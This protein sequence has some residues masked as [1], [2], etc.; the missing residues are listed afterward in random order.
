VNEQIFNNRYRVEGRVGEGGMAV[1]FSGTDVLL[2]RRV[3]IKVLR[4][5]YA[6]D[7]DF[8]RRFY[9]EA[10][11]A[12]R[13]SHPNVVN[14][15]DVGREGETYYIVMELVDGSTLGELIAIDGVL[16]SGIAIDY[17]AQICAGL[18]YAHRQGILH[19]DIKPANILITKDD[20]VKLS[21]FGIARAI[22]ERSLAVT[23]PGMVMGSVYYLSP[24]QAQG[25]ELFEQSDLYSVGVVLFQMLTGKLPFTG[26]SPVTV[27]LKHVS[28]PVPEHELEAAGVSPAVRSVV[29]RLLA[30]APADRFS[31]ASEVA[32]VLR[33]AR[34][35]PT[36]V[37]AG[38]AGGPTDTPTTTIPVVTPPPRRSAS[39]DRPHGTSNGES[40]DVALE[41]RPQRG[42]IGLWA[43][44]AVLLAVGAF[45]GYLFESG[46]P[47]P[48]LPGRTV[49]LG[50]Y[51]GES[52]TQAQQALAVLGITPKVTSIE[53]STIPPDRVVRQTPD[54]GSSVS[55]N[56]TI[57]LF[58]SSGLPMVGVPDVRT[59][60]R[61][62]AERVLAQ[63]KLR[64]KVVQQ[65][66]DAPQDTVLDLKPPAG[67]QVHED[68]L[69]TLVVSQG[70]SPIPVPNV[71][72]MSVDDA[73]AA[74]DKVGLKLQIGERQPSANIPENTIA[75]QDPK[76]GT[77]IPP[78]SAVT[79][80][81][82]GGP[83]PVTVPDVTGK[84]THDAVAMLQ[85]AGLDP[86]FSYMV[87]AGSPG[88]VLREV[89]AAG[90]QANRGAGVTIM[91]TAT[92]LI[93]DVSG[94]SLDDARAGL[95]NAGYNIGN[96]IST[97]DGQPGKV[98]RTDP[99]ANTQLHPGETVNIWYNPGR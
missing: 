42:R 43:A 14:I 79:V 34:E 46:T 86:V 12:A 3:A 7:D 63:A 36:T 41:T 54:A 32:S 39:P 31:S 5:Q 11:S 71:V 92:G 19:R 4:S 29:M 47:F 55:T 21:D 51:V 83:G 40:Y 56:D 74:L 60:S 53:S 73:T 84:S 27:A 26:T 81:V 22:S 80:V 95:Q 99:V 17:A 93:P 18:A 85:A 30:K 48:F 94:M 44:L 75:A 89:P 88:T 9:H 6:I 57:E 20:V 96:V 98:T 25:H 77:K 50:N 13:L 52:S 59:F 65:Y 97:Q 10:E 45:G 67:A 24:E 37:Y 61:A 49:T 82:S 78:G 91:V 58:V 28:E 76:D 72:S 16:P 1:V 2:R 87:Q 64:S 69:V 35:R 15:Y 33:E 68:D 62:D 38:R 8:V 70:K 23:Q 90:T 66:G